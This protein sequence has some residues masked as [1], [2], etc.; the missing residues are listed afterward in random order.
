MVVF[1]YAAGYGA[2]PPPWM[3]IVA[4]FAFIAFT[5]YRMMKERKLTGVD[6]VLTVALSLLWGWILLDG[7]TR[8]HH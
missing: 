1:G 5:A 3:A 6:I 2:P 4:G 7:L 8:L